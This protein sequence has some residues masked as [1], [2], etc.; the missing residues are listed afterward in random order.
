MLDTSHLSSEQR[1][2][3]CGDLPREQR[4]HCVSDLVELLSSIAHEQ[5]IVGKGLNPRRF[6]DSQT[7][8]LQGIGMNE[9]MAVLGYVAR[10]GGCRSVPDLYAEAVR[11]L[12][13]RPVRMVGSQ[14]VQ[15]EVLVSLR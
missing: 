1:S 11:E 10:H 6:A 4:R 13:A 8:A 15:I 2:C 7:S 9:V 14:T 3:N 5:I 12:P